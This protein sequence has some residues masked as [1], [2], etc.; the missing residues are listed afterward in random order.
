MFLL[1]IDVSVVSTICFWK[2]FV[3]EKNLD[4]W[5]TALNLLVANTKRIPVQ[6]VDGHFDMV[7]SCIS[8]LEDLGGIHLM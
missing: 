4:S 5:F 7:D 2:T 8:K 6:K 1:V 3:V